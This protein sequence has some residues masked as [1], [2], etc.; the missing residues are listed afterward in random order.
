MN[1]CVT[2]SDEAA[3]VMWDSGVVV[4]E[5]VWC[6]LPDLNLES[7][8]VYTWEVIVTDDEGV[9]SE[10][11]SSWWEMG[12]L[13][14]AD[15]KAGWVEPEQ[16][17]VHLEDTVPLHEMFA[18]LKKH[19]SYTF[20]YDNMHPCQ[21]LR[22]NFRIDHKIKRARVYITTHGIYRLYI[23]GKP[24]TT[25]E[26]MPGYTAYDKYLSYQTFDLTDLLVEGDNTV[27]VIL[28]DGWYAGRIGG[29]G[30]NCQY[31][32][33]LGLLMQMEIDGQL[34][35]SDEEFRSAT[36]PLCYSDIF[37][38]EKY[39]ARLEIPGWNAQDFDASDW[40]RVKKADY[41]L[42]ILVAEYGEPVQIARRVPAVEIITTPKGETIV[43]FGQVLVGRVEMT[44]QGEAGTDVRL[45][46]CEVLDEHGNYLNNI[47]GR[48]KDQMDVYILKGGDAETH[49]PIF[50]FHGFRYARLTGYPGEVRTENFTV[51]VLA[52][53]LEQ[54]GSFECSNA[55]LNQLQ[56][57]I[58][59]SLLGNTL[60]IPTDC[61]QRERVGWTGDVQVIG[62]T[63]CYNMG[64]M[65]FLKKWMNN[66][67]LEQTENGQVPIIIPFIP[68]YH[69][70]A[71]MPF[72]DTIQP[73]N[74]TSA[75]WGDVVTILP[76]TLYQMYGDITILK[77]YYPAMKKWVEYIRRIAENFNPKNIGEVSPE[78]AERLKYLWN[79]NF[80][81]GD[82][83]TPS[84]C[85]NPETG[86]LDFERSAML[87]LEYVP[88]CF[89]ANSADILS[90]AASLL[91]YD[92]DAVAYAD[93]RKKI[94]DAFAAEYISA[95]GRLKVD[96]Q[97]FHVLALH[98][99][100]VPEQHKRQVVSR[101]SELITKNGDRLDTGFLSVSYLMD[102]L[103]KNGLT[104][105]A[106]KILY[107]EEC[108]SWLYQVKRGATTVWESWQAIKPD[109]RVTKAS[110]N[111]YAYGCVGDW[112]YR[113]IVGIIPTAPGYSE[114]LI[115][116][117]PGSNLGHACGSF[118]SVYG[119]IASEWTQQA[120]GVQHKVTVPVGCTAKI[121]IP[122]PA[123]NILENGVSLNATTHIQ[124]V[125]E[126]NG[127][128]E[129]TIGSGKYAL[130]YRM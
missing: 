1:Y 100:M 127:C 33:R 112:M 113:N 56:S 76:W 22:R 94:G 73:D 89:Y 95:D 55:D 92:E 26:F 129:I 51:E 10:A 38:G 20:N 62:P 48:Y 65:P 97:G 53:S 14:K 81:F 88:A 99:D 61:N 105:K 69:K 75:G 36:G 114:V 21:Y 11:A 57:N 74:V 47:M 72:T 115:Q 116:P 59:W 32:D 24:A 46:H 110:F 86:D 17:P 5:D 85:V 34:V 83:L 125:C 126:E 44:V 41:S 66:L 8:G 12:L 122:S 23:N 43:D 96:M 70:G 79:S 109:G 25:A 104:D 50:T 16:V 13:D 101:L 77:D 30:D 124:N 60:S 19:G 31:G 80:H 6:F 102:V 28:A 84:V 119:V 130:S 63:L 18:Y 27:G 39:D 71:R 123:A 68:A 118:H 40:K 52:S 120:D 3:H 90:K 82:W 2:V 45:E 106:W 117:L 35:L 15:W 108:P 78:R 93:L 58:Y 37:L 98:F 103:V 107:Q 64:A 67:V 4:S 42:D 121:R 29:S 128:T 87:T 49:T 91:G 7:R 111:H 9:S 54:T